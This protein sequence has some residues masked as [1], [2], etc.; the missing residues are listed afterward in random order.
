MPERTKQIKGCRFCQIA[1]KQAPAYVIDENDDDGINVNGFTVVIG[2][3]I[4]DNGKDTSGYGL[5]E[6][7]ATFDCLYG[8]NFF[9]GNDSGATNG[10]VLAIPYDSDTDTNETSGTEG[11][12]DG[13]ND[14]F[15]LTT[16]ATL[17]S[18]AIEL[19]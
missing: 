5:N 2:N 14:D 18:T 10:D 1:R 4:T 16:S 12:T 17:R 15:N 11:Y 9:D 7:G 13:A 6:A 8:W 3:R 19:D